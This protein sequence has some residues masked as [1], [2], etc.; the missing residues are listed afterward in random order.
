MRLQQAL[1]ETKSFDGHISY[2]YRNGKFIYHLGYYGGIVDYESD[3]DQANWSDARVQSVVDY[4]VSR[5]SESL[6]V[7]SNSID[8][9]DS[10]SISTRNV[11]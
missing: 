5:V 9:S 7:R 11:E 8:G 2:H 4:Y 1:E 10:G 6:V 3:T